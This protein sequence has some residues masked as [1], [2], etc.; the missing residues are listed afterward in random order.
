MP[1]KI[2]KGPKKAVS[3]PKEPNVAQM[4]DGTRNFYLEQ[5]QDLE[6]RVLRW[7]AAGKHIS[8]STII[9]TLMLFKL[10]VWLNRQN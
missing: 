6:K 5:I 4:N 3:P 9:G 2:A 10:N 1:P 8:V 7:V